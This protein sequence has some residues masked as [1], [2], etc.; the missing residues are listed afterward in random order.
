MGRPLSI[1]ALAGRHGLSRSTLLHYDRIGLL[2]AEARGANGYRAYGPQA[3]A[4]LARI[5]ELRAAGL[6][7]AEVK[8]A[9]EASTPLAVLLEN[10]IRAIAAAMAA[11]R[12]QQAAVLA[13]LRVTRKPGQVLDK[14]A[15]SGLLRAAGLSDAAMRRWHQ[16]F[17]ARLPEAHAEFLAFLGLGS[18]EIARVRAWSGPATPKE[19]RAR[20]RKTT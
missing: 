15:W 2:R 14:E 6:S 12:T 13:L 18:E 8:A 5:V 20:K 10:R 19:P 11:L 4:R 1:G 17:E 7:L 16:D 9:V 3:Q